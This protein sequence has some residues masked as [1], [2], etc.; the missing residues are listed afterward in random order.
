MTDSEGQ[1]GVLA[2]GF[3]LARSFDSHLTGLFIRPDPR[4]AIPFMGEG[5][6][7]DAIQDLVEASER[8]GRQ[9]A[10]RAKQVFESAGD[11]ASIATGDGLGDAGSPS[12]R[13]HEIVGFIADRV[14]RE[15][16]VA[17]L[18]IVPKPGKSAPRDADDLLHEVLY[19]SGRALLMVPDSPP[20]TVGDNVLVAWNGSAECT[21]AV[22]AALPLLHRAKT[23]TLLRVGEANPDRPGLDALSTYLR[24]HGI[25]SESAERE[26]GADG[27]GATIMAA[28]GE[29]RTDLLVMGAFS[30]SRWREMVL[31]GVTRYAIHN[32]PVPVFMTH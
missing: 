3:R 26:I 12:R 19:R 31:G 1:D 24:R 6:T 9:R 14:G 4:S 5:L 23:V 20:D 22:A 13:W 29:I 2:V 17:D 32:A 30:H 16:R 21:R 15:A 7:A 8:E 25:Q 10:E 11:E 27:V 28:T 18:A